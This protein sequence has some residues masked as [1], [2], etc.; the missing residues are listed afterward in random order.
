M[1]PT[2]AEPTTSNNPSTP[3]PGPIM[4]FGQYRG[5]PLAD[6]P[7]EYLLWLGCLNDLR[8]PLLGYVLREMCRRLAASEARP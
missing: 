2:I 5:T 8:P 4:P 3:S 7:S 1:S 6:L